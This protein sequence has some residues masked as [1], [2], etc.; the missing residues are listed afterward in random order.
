LAHQRA[1]GRCFNLYENLGAKVV[2]W[3]GLLPVMIGAPD[4]GYKSVLRGLM[5]EDKI[6]APW[7]KDVLL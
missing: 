3:R 5:V 7:R 1:P 4:E 2:S 6:R